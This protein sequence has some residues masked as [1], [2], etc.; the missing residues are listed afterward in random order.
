[1]LTKRGIAP[2]FVTLTAWEVISWI[3]F[4]DLRPHPDGSE[5]DG[6]QVEWGDP[7]AAATL[8][9]LEARAAAAPYC[10][11]RPRI[12]DCRPW[13][14]HSTTT[15][16]RH[17]AV[18]GYFVASRDALK[19]ANAASRHSEQ[20]AATLRAELDEDRRGKQLVSDAR[21]ELLAALRTGASPYGRGRMF[22]ELHPKLRTK[23]FLR[24]YFSTRRLSLP[25]GA[26]SDQTPRHR[27]PSSIG[28]V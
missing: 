26:R 22:A 6:F 2:T 8:D 15:K 4:G 18:P 21:R 19:S 14:G 1:M 28:V 13:D 16:C 24:A 27:S 25:F 3:A 9:A 20:L 11:W 12:R 5:R 17:P 10:V 7:P 23:Q